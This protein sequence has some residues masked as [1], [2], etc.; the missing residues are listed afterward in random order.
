MPH[1]GVNSSDCLGTGR[2]GEGS[3][4][5][6]YIGH[7]PDQS[8][9][10]IKWHPLF[11]TLCQ[12]YHIFFSIIISFNVTSKQGDCCYLL[13]KKQQSQVSITP[14]ELQWCLGNCLFLQVS[15][16][17]RLCFSA[18]R[19]F[20]IH[21]LLVTKSAFLTYKLTSLDAKTITLL[22][23]QGECRPPKSL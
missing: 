5:S 20:A 6:T 10:P 2:W 17:I 19:S 12:W 13:S 11:L 15:S 9:C 8:L 16:K 22:T 4:C 7:L 3:L 14:R 21:N 1:Y 18:G 23:S